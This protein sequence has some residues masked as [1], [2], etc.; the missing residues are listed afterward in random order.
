MKTIHKIPL[1]LQDYQQLHILGF[2]RPLCVQMQH[3]Y[4]AFWYEVD[5]PEATLDKTDP[6]L[7]DR[8]PIYTIHM[9]GTGNKMPR[10]RLGYKLQY[11]STVQMDPQGTAVFHFYMELL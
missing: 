10:A 8:L 11:I 7:L 5:T 4:P 2:I 1:A 3:G 9:V 6:T